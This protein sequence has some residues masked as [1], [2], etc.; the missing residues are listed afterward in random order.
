MR[1]IHAKTIVSEKWREI[2]SPETRRGSQLFRY[3]EA[4]ISNN[5]MA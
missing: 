4:P 2:S 1:E 3:N 5:A